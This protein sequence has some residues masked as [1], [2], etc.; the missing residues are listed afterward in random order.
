MPSLCMKNGRRR[1]RG[2]VM[3]NGIRSRQWFDDA[4][5]DSERAA[6]AWEATEKERLLALPQASQETAT[7]WT[8]NA[9]YLGYLAK[10]FFEDGGEIA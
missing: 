3:V 8:I 2:S 10:N 5:K 7:V 4:S 1:W 6:A 9:G